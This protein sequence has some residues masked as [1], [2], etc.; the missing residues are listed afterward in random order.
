MFVTPISGSHA[1][2]QGCGEARPPTVFEDEL[3]HDGFPDVNSPTGQLQH[4]LALCA[5]REEDTIVTDAHLPRS[6][7]NTS[8]GFV[9]LVSHHSDPHA[10]PDLFNIVSPKASFD[11]TLD[12]PFATIRE[13]HLFFHFI[14]HLSLWVDIC[15]PH[16]HFATEIPFRVNN[17][18]ILLNAILACAS[19]HLSII[20]DSADHESLLYANRCVQSLIQRFDDPLGHLDENL[21]AVVILLRLHEEISQEDDARMHLYGQTKVLNAISD[22]A[23]DGGVRES[24]S[25]TSLRQHV[26][27]S[28]TKQRPL[29]LDL[30]NFKHSS[31]FYET[32]NEAYANRIIYIFAKL[33]KFVFPEE[34]SNDHNLYLAQW[35][36]IQADVENWWE[37]KPWY[38]KPLWGEK[39]MT[40][41]TSTTTTSPGQARAHGSF[42]YPE[43]KMAHPAQVVGYQHYHMAKI[44]LILY[45]PSL[46]ARLG[47]AT[48]RTRKET[49][50]VVLT[51]VRQIVGLAKSN[52]DVTNGL[53]QASHILSACGG[54]ICDYEERQVAI[55]FL[56]YIQRKTGWKTEQTVLELQEQ[57]QD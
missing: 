26:Y 43:L 23:A 19:R 14:R 17:N 3:H 27:I 47:F 18:P 53:F 7:T 55:D 16:R 40:S 31:I 9:S 52:E 20:T 54:Y 51:H 38:Y 15:D 22:F 2:K 10:S 46:K 1:Y 33:L 34:G 4:Q 11:R 5:E 48:Y 39:N 32:T 56:K 21:L 42:R 36:E 24:G 49:E 13:S 25:W 57:W 8:D 41:P 50:G 6:R 29:E 44:L 45:D 30:A 12:W 28:L 35:A 37:T